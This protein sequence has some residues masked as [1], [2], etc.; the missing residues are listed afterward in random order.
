MNNDKRDTKETLF[1]NKGWANCNHEY[2]EAT[3]G[4][5]KNMNIAEIRKYL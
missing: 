5:R 1:P 2:M 4:E 3:N